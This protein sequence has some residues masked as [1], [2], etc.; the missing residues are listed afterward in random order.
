[1][2]S[3]LDYEKKCE[4]W[5]QDK[6]N[7]QFQV[8]W[9]LIKDIPNSQ[10]RQIRLENNDNKPVTNSRDTQEILLE[11]GKELL[12]IFSTYKS[13]TSILDDF[14]FYDKRQEQMKDTKKDP[15]PTSPT[16]GSKIEVKLED[17]PTG[18][19]RGNQNRNNNDQ[20]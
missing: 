15:A 5:A 16:T 7:G 12:R 1:M 10:L 9:M 17:I 8:K 13:K 2:L 6:W 3:A 20:Y 19:N 14:S 18:S 11:P 4:L